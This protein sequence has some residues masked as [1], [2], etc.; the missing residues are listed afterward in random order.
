MFIFLEKIP[1]IIA[2]KR[3]LAAIPNAS[4]TV[5]AANPGGSKPKYPAKRIEIAIDIFPINSSVFSER[6]GLN[7]FFTK[8]WETAEE[9]ARSRPAA[10]ERAAAIPP[11]AINAM[12]QLGRFAIS[13]FARTM[14]SAFT[15]SSFPFHPDFSKF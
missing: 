7:T 10:V 9:I 1:N 13:G 8:S 6:S 11:A 14:I 3:E 5:P 15:V 2:G 4:A 12:T